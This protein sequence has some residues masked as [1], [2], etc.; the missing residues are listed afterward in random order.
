MTAQESKNFNIKARCS[1]Q[2]TW[3]IRFCFKDISKFQELTN[4]MA[5]GKQ[6]SK[7]C[8][9]KKKKNYKPG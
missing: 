1:S 5:G 3:K 8:N 9:K 6:I 2:I 7:I 4:D